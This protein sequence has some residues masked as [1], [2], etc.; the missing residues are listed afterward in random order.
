MAIR[1]ATYTDPATGERLAEPRFVESYAGAVLTERERNYHDDSDFYA[2]VWDEAEGRI[3]NVE[4]ATTRF[5]GTDRNSATPDATPEVKAKAREWLKNWYLGLL[6]S[7]NEAASHY[8]KPGRK[9]KVVAGR[10]VPKG[11]TGTVGFV[12]RVNYGRSKWTAY[13]AATFD[14]D[15]AADGTRTRYY[16]VNTRNLEVVDPASYLVPDAELEAR[17][18]RWAAGECWH[19]MAYL[20]PGMVVV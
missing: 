1:T 7:E 9:V 16:G 11:T 5:G 13:D 10:K 15:P 18:E 14:A 3:K 4:Y 20:T 12:E 8:V 6:K 2:V 17:A 19:A